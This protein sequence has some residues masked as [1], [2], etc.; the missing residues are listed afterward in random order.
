MAKKVNKPVQVTHNG[1]TTNYL[2]SPK[3]RGK[4]TND[5][6]VWVVDVATEIACFTTCYQSGWHNGHSGWSFV[7][8]G[9]R[10]LLTL[11]HNL[12]NPQLLIAKF[13]TDQNQWH[14]YPADVRH[15]PAD[16][17]LPPILLNWFQNGFISKS[18]MTRIK[19]GQL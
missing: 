13:V 8:A 7:V 3:H 17:P 5:V 12:R 9:V 14:G 10:Q 16:K 19:Q 1:N 4:P 15:K 2:V 6:S 11:G 18:L